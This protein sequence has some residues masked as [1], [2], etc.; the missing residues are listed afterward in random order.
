VIEV[1]SAPGLES[2]T[3]EAWVNT[4]RVHLADLAR[5]AVQSAA[6]G[7]RSAA[8]ANR[9]NDQQWLDD[10]ANNAQPEEA[11]AIRRLLGRMG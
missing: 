8:G 4:I 6:R 1:N 5:P 3:L 11:A 7:Q 10:L 9:D 2:S